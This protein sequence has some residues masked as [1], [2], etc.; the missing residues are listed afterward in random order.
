MDMYWHTMGVFGWMMMI[1]FS[2]AVV[3]FLIWLIRSTG[4]TG[5]RHE[6]DALSILERRLASGEIDPEEFEDR[7]RLLGRS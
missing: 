2:V 6:S 7:K 5:Q 1:L 4:F 3:A